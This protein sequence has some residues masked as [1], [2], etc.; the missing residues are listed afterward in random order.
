M[1]IDMAYPAF[2]PEGN[3]HMLYGSI[4]IKKQWTCRSQPGRDCEFLQQWSQPSGQNNGVIIEKKENIRLS[5]PGPRITGRSK[6]PVFFKANALKMCSE[7]G[8]P[9]GNKLTCRF[10]GRS[11]I[12]NNDFHIGRA[13]F[14]QT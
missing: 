13:V 5:R 12:H 4:F 10:I 8:L 2:W 9:Q 11:V 14:S 6:I 1:L 3:S 7:Q